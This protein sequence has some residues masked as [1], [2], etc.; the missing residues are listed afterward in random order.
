MTTYLA[1]IAVAATLYAAKMGLTIYR[2]KE[3]F[4]SDWRRVKKSQGID[5]S[6]GFWRKLGFNINLSLMFHE[7]AF[8]PDR[9][10]EINETLKAIQKKID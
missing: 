6:W 3:F 4:V 2:H 7:N 1:A 8:K 10:K 5:E 9:L